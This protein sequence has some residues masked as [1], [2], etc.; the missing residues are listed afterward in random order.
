MNY[1]YL[2]ICALLALGA[3][4]HAQTNI[5][6]G[7]DEENQLSSLFAGYSELS[8]EAKHRMFASAETGRVLPIA[9][10]SDRSGIN[11]CLP[12]ARGHYN[13][14]KARLKWTVS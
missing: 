14:R 9:E 7:F 11:G 13:Y 1:P 4:A 8:A 12:A 5:S 2:S 3:T 10:S 6:V